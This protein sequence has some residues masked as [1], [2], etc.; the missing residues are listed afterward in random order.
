MPRVINM[1]GLKVPISVLAVAFIVML[2]LTCG[3]LIAEDVGTEPESLS[4][5]QQF[6][7][8]ATIWLKVSP[9]EGGQVCISQNSLWRSLTGWSFTRPVCTTTSWWLKVR[10]GRSIIVSVTPKSGYQ[11]A[12]IMFTKMSS[13]T[14]VLLSTLPGCVGP[15]VGP[16]AQGYS[17]LQR[18]TQSFTVSESGVVTASFDTTGPPTGGPCNADH[19]I[20]QC[21]TY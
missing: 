16:C 1:V 10:T 4:M 20:P 8:Y 2:G 21:G 18:I 7:G 13:M 5:P 6:G 15:H 14:S 11:F 17:N 19:H 9:F 12:S 3:F